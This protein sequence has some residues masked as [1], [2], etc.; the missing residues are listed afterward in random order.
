MIKCPPV[1]LLIFNRPNLTEKVMDQIREVEPKK[2]FIG[3]DGPRSDHPEDNRS[4]EEARRVASQVDWNC[5]VHTLFR[6][7]NLGT[8]QAIS[9]AVTWFF[10]YVE[11]GIILEDDCVPSSSFFS[12]CG[13]L[14]KRYR[15]DDRVVMISGN[16]PLS[17][18]KN[19]DQSYHFS[20]YG[21]IWGW[22]TWRDQWAAYHEAAQLN[23]PDFIRRVLQNVLV[24]PAQV[25]K[26]TQSILGVLNGN[27]DSWDYQWFWARM[28]GGR[29]AVV[30]AHNLIS[31]IGFGENASR[32]SNPD[33]PRADL[34]VH[35][36]T[37]PLS[38]PEGVFPD[39]EYD[40]EWFEMTHGTGPSTLTGKAIDYFRRQ[41]RRVVRKGR[42]IY[43]TVKAPDDKNE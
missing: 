36:I 4:C 18:W 32:T 2:L 35:D 21:G 5:E 41:K 39:R 12:F 31:N 7:E 34:N 25:E 17:P 28:L 1:L 40:T 9:S 29:L 42:E 20:N 22:A 26:R 30:P 23:E 33:D 27:I 14:L 11:E 6:E 24:E 8:K 16:N 15:N 13:T 43:N 37:F 10:E 38:D 19:E 3:A